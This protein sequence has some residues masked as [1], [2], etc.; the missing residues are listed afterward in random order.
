LTGEKLILRL[1][2]ITQQ[3]NIAEDQIAKSIEAGFIE[4]GSIQGSLKRLQKDLMTKAL[5][6]KYITVIDKNGDPI[7]Y[8]IKSY[9]EL[10]ARTKLQETS[11][12]AVLNTAAAT[13]SDLVQ[14]SSHNTKSEICIPFEG[15][16]FSISGNNKDFPKLYE[17]SPFHPNCQHTMTVVFEEG[18]EADGT[19]DKYSDFSKGITEQ[20]PTRKSWIPPSERT[21]I[22]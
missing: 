16:I 2:R 11:T 6:G 17:A 22:K 1:A 3:V 9:S 20:H 7:S 15:K 5:D 14:V 13:G 18:L 21:G 12:D 4:S 19:Y 8:K 10:V